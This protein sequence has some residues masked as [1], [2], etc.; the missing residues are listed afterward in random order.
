MLSA[1]LGWIAAAAA[2]GIFA[3]VFLGYPSRTRGDRC[4]RRA[5]LATVRAAAEAVFPPGGAIACSGLEAG[6]PDYVDR[7]FAHAPPRSRRLMRLLFFS[8]EHGTAIFPAPGGLRGFRRFSSLDL[9]QR[10]ALLEAWADSRFFARRL[11]FSSLRAILTLGYFA[12]PRV[13][14]PLGLA[15]YEIATPICEADLFYPRIGAH[16]SAIPWT[17]ADLT[18]P[19]PGAP[20]DLDDPRMVRDAGQPA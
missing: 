16:P 2:V 6:I 9:E 11:L 10:I 15:P 3:R 12:H 1:M 4:L 7:L 13:M 19:T 18:A 14:D 8:I 5:E 17:R 20:I